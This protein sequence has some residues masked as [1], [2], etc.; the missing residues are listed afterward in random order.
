VQRFHRSVFSLI[1]VVIT[2]VIIIV[3][4]TVDLIGQY[5]R[6]ILLYTLRFKNRRIGH[7]NDISIFSSECRLTCT[8][9]ADDQSRIFIDV[10]RRTTFSESTSRHVQSHFVAGRCIQ[11]L[12]WA[13]PSP[14]AHGNF[15]GAG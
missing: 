15:F 14:V 2:I 5:Y 3:T 9:I 1:S 8:F 7:E 13:S 6:K 11:M 4:A 12:H 10:E